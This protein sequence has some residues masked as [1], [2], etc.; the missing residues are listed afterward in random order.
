MLSDPEEVITT[1]HLNRSLRSAQRDRTWLA[2]EL[3]TVPETV[4]GNLNQLGQTQ[5]QLAEALEREKTKMV[6]LAMHL[7]GALET[8]GSQKITN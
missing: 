5:R 7:D 1:E 2:E 3:V 4:R 8:L 6:E